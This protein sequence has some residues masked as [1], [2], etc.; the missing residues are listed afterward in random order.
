VSRPR[1][2]CMLDVV[3]SQPVARGV[4]VTLCF[5]KIIK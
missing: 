4:N 3:S 1:L 2:H 5:E